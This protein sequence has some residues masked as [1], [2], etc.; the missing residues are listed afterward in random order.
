MQSKVFIHPFTVVVRRRS[1]SF[2]VRCSSSPF[3]VVRRSSSSFVVVDHRRSSLFVVVL[4][5]CSSVC[6]CGAAFAFE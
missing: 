3:V 2:V 4:P 6:L 1:L 5:V